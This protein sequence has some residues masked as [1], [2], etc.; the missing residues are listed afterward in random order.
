LIGFNDAS[1]PSAVQFVS[2]G[3]VTPTLRKK[4]FTATA[5]LLKIDHANFDLIKIIAT[6]SALTVADVQ[7]HLGDLTL[8][9]PCTKY[10]MN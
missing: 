4:I 1:A 7:E 9:Y 6:S 2:Y 10:R 5:N 8:I 3:T